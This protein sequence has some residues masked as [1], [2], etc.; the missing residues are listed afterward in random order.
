MAHVREA[1][2]PASPRRWI[3]GVL[4]RW[5]VAVAVSVA[6][7]SVVGL[8]LRHALAGTALVRLDEDLARRLAAHRTATR[9]RLTLAGT[10]IAEPVPVAVLWALAVV[11]SYLWTRRVATA[12]FA[13]LAIGGEKLSYLLTTLVVRRP[14]PDVPPVGKVYVTSSFP[15]GHV[16]SAISTYGSI[17]VLVLFRVVTRQNR[18]RAGTAVAVVLVGAIAT[19]VA[20]SRMYRGQHFLTDVVAGA[21]LGVAW[22]AVTARLVGLPAPRGVA[23][24]PHPARA[25]RAGDGAVTAPPGRPPRAPAGPGRRTSPVPARASHRAR[26]A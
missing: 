21:L 17:A 4:V 2:Q 6:L 23:D 18:R 22:L 1:G 26:G 19:A 24:A 9:D 16:G 12:A 3:G 10:S 13:L 11:A 14:R 5:L 25:R 20:V 8:L 15:S 7:A